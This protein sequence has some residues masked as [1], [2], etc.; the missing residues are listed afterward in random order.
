[1]SGAERDPRVPLLLWV[2]DNPHNNT[3][4]MRYA[5]QLGIHVVSVTSTV[6]AK[7]WIESNSG[8]LISK[9]IKEHL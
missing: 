7:E 4:E 9:T 5:E 2:D 1:M 8:E 3:E 6:S